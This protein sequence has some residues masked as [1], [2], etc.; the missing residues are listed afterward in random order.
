MSRIHNGYSYRTDRSGD[1]VSCNAI[2]CDECEECGEEIDDGRCGCK[3]CDCGETATKSH[4]AT[5]TFSNPP[6][7]KL[8]HL[9]DGCFP[10]Y[11]SESEFRAQAMISEG[12]D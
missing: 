5:V 10:E 7:T 12:A 11:V 6:A 9:C 4:L 3:R 8:V 1:L 2:E